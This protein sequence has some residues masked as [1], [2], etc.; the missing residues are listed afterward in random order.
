LLHSESDLWNHREDIHITHK[1]DAEK[2]KRQRQ[3]EEGED[4]QAEMS[5]AATTKRHRLQEKLEDD[6]SKAP[7]G[8]KATP[9]SRSKDSLGHTFVN[10][11]APRLVDGNGVVLT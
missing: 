7:K 1:P 6:D 10:G 8:Q 2:R 3:W 11:I 4:K 9:N 5:G